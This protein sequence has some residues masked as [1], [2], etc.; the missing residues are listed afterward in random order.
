MKG[1]LNS[2][3][4]ERL[5][6]QCS[7]M[8]T[9]RVLGEYLDCESRELGTNETIH[10][11]VYIRVLQRTNGVCVYYIVNMLNIYVEIYYK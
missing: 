2:Q 1:S 4:R 10:M 11:C 9:Q 6:S 5:C 3:S 8:K 7:Q